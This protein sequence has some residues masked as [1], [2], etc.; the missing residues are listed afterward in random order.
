VKLKPLAAIAAVIACVLVPATA[1]AAPP[2]TVW[3]APA[4]TPVS[5]L[6]NSC[7][8]PG[9]NTI[10][11]AI[12]AVPAGSTINICAGTYVEQPQIT[13]A[14]SLIGH[15]AVTIKLPAAPAN[16][17]TACDVASN[18]ATSGS[19]Q[20]GISICTTGTVSITDVTVDAAWPGGTCDDDLYGIL[21]GGGATLYMTG[22]SVAAA[23][24]VP[25]D[26]CQ[27]GVGIQV[28][29]AWTTPNQVGRAQLDDVHVS[30]Y[31]KNGITVDGA[32]S[33]ADIVGTTV[34][35]I[36][37]TPSIAQN[38]IQISNG[39]FGDI[40]S[41]TITGNECNEVGACGLND[42]QGGGVLFDGAADGS[43]V[44]GSRITGNDYGVYSYDADAT[45]PTSPS[46]TL[47]EDIIASRYEGVLL[48]QGFTQIDA[49]SITGGAIGL[50]VYQYDGQS[51]A[52]DGTAYNDTIKGA[53]IAAVDVQSDD[54]AT[55]DFP[56]QLTVEFSN[57]KGNAARVLNNSTNYKVV[58]L[59][60]Q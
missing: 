52:A 32:D 12:N 17:T 2:K 40:F 19:N 21:V 35:G 11:S 43:S 23:G 8:H 51:Y 38:G 33:L 47:E 29:M 41:S 30:G 53:S 37:P 45:A 50:D 1:L 15:G 5:A 28:G 54:A 9:Y 56:G 39:A 10:Q 7:T 57:L 27:G 14:V 42:A 6:D 26:G 44:S 3:V 4:P 34:T 59:G 60:D 13:Q 25:L 46:V 36:G 24:A 31:Q 20:D 18:A 58:L 16:A 49:T 48:D 55:G 22:S